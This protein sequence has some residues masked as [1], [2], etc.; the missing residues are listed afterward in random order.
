MCGECKGMVMVAGRQEGTQG[1]YNRNVKREMGIGR[2]TRV[3]KWGRRIIL[4]RED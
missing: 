3:V 4:I 1:K 2:I